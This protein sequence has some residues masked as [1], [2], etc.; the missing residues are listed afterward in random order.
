MFIIYKSF[1]DLPAVLIR[2]PI[3]PYGISLLK[4]LVQILQNN[5]TF[6]SFF[7]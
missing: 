6:I 7:M 2:G 1:P 5:V 4:L 3:A